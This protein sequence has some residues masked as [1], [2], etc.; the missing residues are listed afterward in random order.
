[1]GSISRGVQWWVG[2]TH[3]RTHTYTLYRA[4]FPA[5]GR[6]AS[7]N[8]RDGI[9]RG[10]AVLAGS[11]RMP[12]YHSRTGPGPV[13]RLIVTAHLSHPL[14]MYVRLDYVL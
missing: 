7:R 12:C 13:R 8:R 10:G 9:D 2:V 1:M 14:R 5:R 4:C 6:C 3:T 11:W